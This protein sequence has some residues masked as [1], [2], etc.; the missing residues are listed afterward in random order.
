MIKWSFTNLWRSND[1]AKWSNFGLSQFCK[2]Q[3]IQKWRFAVSNGLWL[4]HLGLCNFF[5]YK[6]HY[7]MKEL[8]L[9]RLQLCSPSSWFYSHLHFAI[10]ILPCP[11]SDHTESTLTQHLS[12][13]HILSINSPALQ[14]FLWLQPNFFHHNS[15]WIWS[16]Q[17]SRCRQC[18]SQ[19]PSSYGNYLQRPNSKQ[20]AT[21]GSRVD[22]AA[23]RRCWDIAEDKREKLMVRTYVDRQPRRGLQASLVSE[24]V[25]KPTVERDF[26]AM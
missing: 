26:T 1:E 21:I 4:F 7:V 14:H 16:S 18:Q 25:A 24:K 17:A 8:E 15:L 11:S 10:P 3:M 20:A 2:D 6:S 19:Y 13:F 22:L 12:K 5:D 23:R 9:L